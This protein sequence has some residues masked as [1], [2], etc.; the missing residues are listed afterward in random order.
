MFVEHY[1]V[2]G[3]VLVVEHPVD[4]EKAWL[5]LARI[6]YERVSAYL[7]AD[8]ATWKTAGLE[9]RETPNLEVSCVDAWVDG[10]RKLLDVRTPAVWESGAVQGAEWI[11]LSH[12]PDRLAEVPEGPLAVMCGSGYRSPMAASL[13]EQAGRMD[14][15]N[16]RGGWSAYTL[17]ESPEPDSQD[18]FCRKLFEQMPAA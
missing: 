15:V 14:V 5:E 8:L 12:L 10:G 4:A 6:G 7:L 1:F 2:E 13:L 17:R 16:V 9:V 11:P 3:L 18:L